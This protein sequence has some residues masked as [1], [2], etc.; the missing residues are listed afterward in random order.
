M[1][2]ILIMIGIIIFG[3]FA[4]GFFTYAVLGF[5]DWLSQDPFNWIVD[6][7]LTPYIEPIDFQAC[8]DKGGIP[9]RSSWNGLFKRC[10]VLSK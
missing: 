9:I 7:P 8:R 3:I 6:R 2:E 5:I 1:K 4:L 10:D